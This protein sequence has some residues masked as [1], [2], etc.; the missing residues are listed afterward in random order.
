MAKKTA[1]ITGI[2]GQD[3]AYLAEFLLS[4]GYEVHGLLR[5]DSYAQEKYGVSRL[6]D[7]GIG[8]QVTLHQ[9]DLTDA[10]NVTAVLKAVNP[11]EIYNLG[12]LSHVAVSFEAPASVF[13]INTKGVLAVLEAVR[14][15]DM[16]GRVRIYQ[17]SSSEMFG[18]SLPPQNED[19][20]MHP[21]SPYGAAKL[22]AFWLV[23]TYR[24]S[25][26]IH[27]SNGILFN[28]ESPLR[29]EGFVTHKITRAVA[30]I[31]AGQREALVLG[32]L[33]SARDWGH[34]RDYVRGMWLM[35]QKDAADDY[36]LATGQA[37]SVREFVSR[38]F[39][40][41]GITIA[42]QGQGIDEVGVDALSGHALVRVDPDLFRPNEVNA[43]L[44]DATKACDV[45]GWGPEVALDDL[46]EEMLA[47]DRS[48]LNPTEKNEIWREIG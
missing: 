5:W 3:G 35:L 37:V 48:A 31:E 13:D 47:A 27:A 15:L 7:L 32:N 39:A 16:V 23:K 1:L 44:G 6:F 25:Y 38:A 40:L 43:L 18:S 20:P 4:K 11:D 45:L 9:G 29:G 12:A 22:A 10:Q 8:E 46:I 34:A 33:N 19:T 26:G 28:H 42:W 24:D 41:I 2:T 30:E 14:L 36:V 21:C 17:A